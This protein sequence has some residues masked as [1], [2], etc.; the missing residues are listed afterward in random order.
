MDTAL[1]AAGDNG[2]RPELS[3]QTMELED[4][5][6]GSILKFYFLENR[7]CGMILRGKAPG[8]RKMTELLRER[9]TAE[10]TARACAGG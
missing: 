6:K 10:E 3:Y 9:A 5:E 7:L 8:L 4:R 2:K 1:F